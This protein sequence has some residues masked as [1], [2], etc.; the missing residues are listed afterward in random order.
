MITL[1]RSQTFDNWLRRLRDKTAQFRILARLRNAGEGNFGDVKPVGE[2]VM[3][4]RVHVG[5]GYRVYYTARGN[6]VV[7]LLM[8]GDKSTQQIDIRRARE[9]ARDIRNQEPPCKPT[10]Q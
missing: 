10:I 4:M 9:M 8:G 7:F 1:I 6:T 3:E 5:P 2:G